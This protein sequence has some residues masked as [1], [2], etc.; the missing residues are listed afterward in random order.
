[1]IDSKIHHSN[2]DDQY[3]A[4]N[5]LFL[6]FFNNFL[7]FISMN[8]QFINRDEIIKRTIR[9]VSF[10]TSLYLLMLKNLVKTH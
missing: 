2:I 7:I 10:E 3:R 8:F 9:K 5:T 6:I 1:M 4:Y